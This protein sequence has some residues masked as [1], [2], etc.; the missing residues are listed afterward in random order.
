MMSRLLHSRT[1]TA[2]RTYPAH[3]NSLLGR[4]RRFRG[5]PTHFAPEQGWD[6]T[7][8]MTEYFTVA[9]SSFV[10]GMRLISYPHGFLLFTTSRRNWNLEPVWL[11]LAVGKAPRHCCWRRHSRNPASSALTTTTNP[12]KRRET[13]L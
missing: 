12:S 5:S 3:S 10:Q 13:Q 2:R 1:K 4:W 7:N 8:M 11:M 6:G 9:R